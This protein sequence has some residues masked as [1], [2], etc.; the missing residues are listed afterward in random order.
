MSLASGKLLLHYFGDG[1]P[2]LGRWCQGKVCCRREERLSV[3]CK[4]SRRRAR[5]YCRVWDSSPT[6]FCS[7]G[8]DVHALLHSLLQC[9]YILMTSRYWLKEKAVRHEKHGLQWWCVNQTSFQFVM[10]MLTLD[11]CV[12]P[13]HHYH[14]NMCLTP[15]EGIVQDAQ[16]WEEIRQSQPKE[17]I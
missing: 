17:S 6:Y 7:P 15:A 9:A 5:H 16:T 12:H 1:V 14:T 10:Y 4:Y 8:W 2:Q 13:S 11:T 3:S